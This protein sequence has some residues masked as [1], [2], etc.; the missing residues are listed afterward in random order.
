MEH[1]LNVSPSSRSVIHKMRHFGPEKDIRSQVG[2]LLQ[3]G[4][5]REVHFPTWLSNVVLAPKATGKW[6][7]CVD[8]RDLNKA[9]PKTV[10]H[11]PGLINSSIPPRV[12]SCSVSWMPIRVSS[13]FTDREG[14]A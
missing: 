4:H 12:T 6:R 13:N 5:I 2:D 10:I 11:F 1:R 8:F 9:F 14:S 7:M 3:V